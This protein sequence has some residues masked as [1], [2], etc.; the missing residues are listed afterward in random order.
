M[1]Y[2]IIQLHNGEQWEDS[3]YFNKC[4][5]IVDTDD[6][7]KKVFDNKFGRFNITKDIEE[8]IRD[9]YNIVDI[10]YPPKFDT[11]TNWA[12]RSMDRWNYDEEE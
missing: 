9:N 4:I 7:I 3:H 11:I 10:I 8:F 5:Y 12:D 6:D 2:I 1:K